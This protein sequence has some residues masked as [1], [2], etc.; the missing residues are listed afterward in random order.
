MILDLAHAIASV[1]IDL[2]DWDVDGAVFCTYKYLNSGMGGL[3]TMFINEKYKDREPGLKGRHGKFLP[4]M[5]PD[6]Y[7]HKM[8]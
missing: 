3:G 2:D 8:F 7:T 5:D 1:P 4:Y 6:C